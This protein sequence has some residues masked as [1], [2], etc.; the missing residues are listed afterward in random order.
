MMMTPTVW[1][2]AGLLRKY[3]AQKFGGFL[4]DGGS[5]DTFGRFLNMAG[6]IARLTGKSR[7]AVIADLTADVQQ[8]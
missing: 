3:T 5:P 6:R 8:P 1:N 4:L 2:D 7:D